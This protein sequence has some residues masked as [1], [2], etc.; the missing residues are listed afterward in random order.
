MVATK[1]ISL[2]NSWVQ[3]RTPLIVVVFY[4]RG[5]SYPRAG[6]F[7]EDHELGLIETLCRRYVD[8]IGEIVVVLVSIL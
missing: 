8:P 6:V 1:V 5:K 3:V 2:V 4:Q 7:P